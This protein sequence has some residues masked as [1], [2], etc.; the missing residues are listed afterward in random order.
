MFNFSALWLRIVWIALLCILVIIFIL[1]LGKKFRII[2]RILII[3]GIILIFGLCSRSTIKGLSNP[4]IV[5]FEAT[6]EKS[7][8]ANGVNPFEFQYCF[9]SGDRK[10]F[11]DLDSFSKRILYNKPLL[12][13][14]TY[15]IYY[16]KQTNL[17]I[18]IYRK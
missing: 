8:R 10:Y 2:Y 13:G 18:A 17:I 3:T 5:S 15:T 6:F 9:D 7:Y 4:Q 12:V 14:K 16:E 1:V 11:V